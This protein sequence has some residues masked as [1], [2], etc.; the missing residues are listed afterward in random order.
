[1]PILATME[2]AGLDEGLAL[3]QMLNE[4][5]EL[6]KQG[7]AAVENEKDKRE[8][9]MENQEETDTGDKI[10][11]NG[12]A[13]IPDEE[14][15]EKPELTEID[16]KQTT[17]SNESAR[18]GNDYSPS[19]EAF[20]AGESI[21]SAGTFF[22]N[23]VSGLVVML[24]DL[25]IAYGPGILKFIRVSVVL[26]LTSALRLLAKSIIRIS[27]VV[28][29]MRVSMANQIRNIGKLKSKTEVLVRQNSKLSPENKQVS[30]SSLAEWASFNGIVDFDNAVEN[31]LKFV[32]DVTDFA[33]NR[34]TYEIGSIERMFALISRGQTIDIS[35]F[36]KSRDA[37]SGFKAQTVSGY[38]IDDTLLTTYVYPDS[39]P[40]RAF[41]TVSIPKQN[42]SYDRDV[43]FL[44][45]MKK[46][47]SKSS[48]FIGVNPNFR[49]KT[50][51]TVNY[52]EAAKLSAFIS[53][54]DQLAKQTELSL[55]FYDTTKAKLSGLKGGYKTYLQWLIADER[56]R[57]VQESYAEMIAAKQGFISRVYLPGMM[58]V[59]EYVAAFLYHARTFVNLNIKALER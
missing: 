18:C 55:S 38:D 13:D 2:A 21:R 25:G 46:A 4:D 14:T 32:N 56:Q 9:E 57:S 8:T 42:L 26:L 3:T 53:K 52:M 51:S 6:N 1:M 22:A 41:L 27:D 15:E 59:H 31:M 47:Y 44:E 11:G 30:N 54:L 7:L 17:V 40:N 43:G 12:Q 50:G 29:R 34:V 16:G 19:T 58:D 48:M 36:A 49:L 23:A 35:E 39:L 28:Q 33:T 45:T 24:R 10:T 37:I 5:K 20:D